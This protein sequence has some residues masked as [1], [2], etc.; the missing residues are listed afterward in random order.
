MNLKEVSLNIELGDGGECAMLLIQPI[1]PLEAVAGQGFQIAD[2]RKRTA[3][4]KTVE[5]VCAYSKTSICQDYDHAHFLI[6]PE[7][8]L[9]LEGFNYIEK[10]VRSN[11]C[12]NDTVIIAGLEGLSW[13]VFEGL[14]DR[15]DNPKPCYKPPEGTVDWVNCSV[16]LVKE[17]TGEV[18]LF[19][20]SKFR[21]SRFEQS[22]GRIFEGQD[23]LLFRLKTNANKD[24]SFISLICSDFSAEDGGTTTI[25]EA[26]E[27]IKG[28]ATNP[29][30]LEFIIGL[31]HNR[32]L[33][34]E[35]FPMVIQNI[36]NR[37]HS[38]LDLQD[39]ALVF[40][41]GAR[42]QTEDGYGESSFF[43]HRTSWAII[44]KDEVPSEWYDT[45]TWPGDCRHYRLMVDSPCVFTLQYLP[46]RKAGRNS[47]SI[48]LPFKGVIC[49]DILSDGNLVRGEKKGLHIVCENL[50]A[51]ADSFSRNLS[52]APGGGG[53]QER[54]RG[55]YKEYKRL[56][57]LETEARLSQ[58]TKLLFS[59]HN[60]HIQ[61][62]YHW[63]N[64]AHGKPLVL[65]LHTMSLLRALGKE[66]EFNS[67]ALA[68]AG[69][70]DQFYLAVLDGNDVANYGQMIEKYSREL[71]DIP[72]RTGSSLVI[73]ARTE[74]VPPSWDKARPCSQIYVEQYSAASAGVP[75]PDDAH[76]S[77]KEPMI[78]FIA[79]LQDWKAKGD[80]EKAMSY[81]GGYL[82]Q[83]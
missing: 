18:K 24:F 55:H 66:L 6:M 63:T 51:G 78:G 28:Q 4:L 59:Q 62:Y 9:T 61:N 36:F 48:R 29:V 26:L 13:D 25:N 53:L 1:V 64:S 72:L 76:F 75:D 54:I 49:H 31:L 70:S 42:N 19:V 69:I 46:I 43:F 77:P 73:L 81:L 15:S 38:E 35:P 39:T 37:D 14:L 30:N 16:T 33:K 10:Y 40:V 50:L 82:G 79:H 12:P 65:A 11:D 83:A 32:T 56:L 74:A 41:N 8:S 27:G 80:E 17:H 23:L 57:L 71:E 2:A 45:A 5:A 52:S 44:G 58:I 68:I 60:P 34:A 22:R 20:Q 7:L 67:D 47:G 3:S 21:A